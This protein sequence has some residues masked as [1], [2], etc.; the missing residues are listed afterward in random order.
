M[1]YSSSI[2]NLPSSC[3]SFIKSG[4]VFLLG[5]TPSLS[6]FV[7]PFSKFLFRFKI[8]LRM[9]CPKRSKKTFLLKFRFWTKLL[10]KQNFSRTKLLVGHNFSHP[11]KILSLLTDFVLS[12]KVYS[13]IEAA[14]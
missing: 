2:T 1:S 13:L 6:P 5:F 10:V 9:E 4:F 8:M 7:L 12:D 14:V 3:V 11:Q